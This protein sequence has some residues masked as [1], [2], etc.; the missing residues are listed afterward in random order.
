MPRP[1]HAD[2]EPAPG[3]ICAT[4]A[5]ADRPFPAPPLALVTLAD[6]DLPSPA[7]PVALAA[8]PVPFSNAPAAR[9]LLPRQ[10]EPLHRD[11]V[12]PPVTPLDAWREL[13]LS[14]TLNGRPVSD[15]TLFAEDPRDGRLAIELAMLQLW[16]VQ[17]DVGDILTFEGDALLPAGPDPG[18]H[19]EAR[20]RGPLGR[21]RDPASASP[22]R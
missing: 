10:G 9:S 3:P 5:D 22:A 13:V 19:L 16:R 18:D 15:G 17:T 12:E 11:P 2:D 7:P 20:S 6:A 1:P 21:G 4:L 14:V 8:P